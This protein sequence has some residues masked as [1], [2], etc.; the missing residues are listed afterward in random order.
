[1]LPLSWEAKYAQNLFQLEELRLENLVIVCSMW[2]NVFY[3]TSLSVSRHNIAVTESDKHDII[4][5]LV[6]KRK[7]YCTYCTYI[8]FSFFF[9]FF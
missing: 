1:M 2:L 5:D 9:I 8:P 6:K 3:F 7:S 4:T